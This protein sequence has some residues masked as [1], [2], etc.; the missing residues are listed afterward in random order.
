[1]KQFLCGTYFKKTVVVV[2]I[3]FLTLP[4]LSKAAE[5]ADSTAKK[6]KDGYVE[7]VSADA[8]SLWFT[9]KYANPGG[10]QFSLV[11]KNSDGDILFR[12]VF[13][14]SDFYRRIKMLVDDKDTIPSFIIKSS[15]GS[16]TQSFRINRMSQST[17]NLVTVTRL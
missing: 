2:F 8:G 12:G 15:T 1:M 3:A 13:A 17:E 5:G 7:Y 14:G 10:G 11:V 6:Q 16:V 9:I 4:V